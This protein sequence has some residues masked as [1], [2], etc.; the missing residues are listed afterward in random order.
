MPLFCCYTLC[1]TWSVEGFS[2]KNTFW[3]LQF[4]SKLIH[5][6]H[7]GVRHF[8]APT[9]C[10]KVSESSQYE[11]NKR[12][13]SYSLFQNWFI[14]HIGEYATFLLLQ[15]VPK[16]LS[17]GNMNIINVSA[18]TVCFKFD[19]FTTSGCMQL[20]CSY[21]L[22][23]T[24]SF[25]VFWAK[26]TLAPT[27]CFKIDSFTTSGCM[28]LFCCYS[29]CQTWSVEGFWVKL[30]FWLLQFVSKFIHSRHR[31]VCHFSAPTV[32]TKL[33]QSRYSG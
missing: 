24:W 21:S 10:T 17:R 1:Q 33:D 6:Q 9:V 22:C 29:L 28:P 13:G 15:F 4:V 7:R 16:L 2:V 30:T 26:Q 27:V 31:G 3:L 32:C 19:S 20:F 14:H 11:Y 23:Q 12:F 18:P 5:S 8:S 25:E